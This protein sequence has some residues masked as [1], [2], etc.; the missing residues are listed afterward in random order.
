ML[1]HSRDLSSSDPSDT[2]VWFYSRPPDHLTAHRSSE[3]NAEGFKIYLLALKQTYIIPSWLIS[4]S[5]TI[6]KNKRTSIMRDRLA[7]GRMG[8]LFS[9]RFVYAFRSFICLPVCLNFAGKCKHMM[10]LTS[11]THHII[12]WTIRSVDRLMC[13]VAAT[14]IIA[15]VE[16]GNQPNNMFFPPPR[17]SKRTGNIIISL[18]GD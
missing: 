4:H 8:V 9:D 10:R 11:H 1:R 5:F 18:L 13:V 3:R 16:C 7:A 2:L 15:R 14:F 12:I 17:I 6:Y